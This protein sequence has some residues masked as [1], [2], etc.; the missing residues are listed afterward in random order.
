MVESDGRERRSIRRASPATRSSVGRPANAAE[1]RRCVREEVSAGT[2]R[3]SNDCSHGGAGLEERISLLEDKLFMLNAASWRE[4]W[5]DAKARDCDGIWQTV[6]RIETRVEEQL[7]CL[8]TQ[9]DDLNAGVLDSQRTVRGLVRDLQRSLARQEEFDRT[10]AEVWACLDEQGQQLSEA[11]RLMSEVDSGPEQ[12]ERLQAMPPMP[13]KS[14]VVVPKLPLSQALLSFNQDL[15]PAAAAPIAPARPA[16]ALKAEAAAPAHAGPMGACPAAVA[17]AHGGFEAAPRSSPVPPPP[18]M[19]PPGPAA[20]PSP[21]LSLHAFPE[22]R[23]DSVPHNRFFAQA[24]SS[25]RSVSPYLRSRITPGGT[26]PHVPPSPVSQPQLARSQSPM[27]RRRS[28]TP[29]PVH[30]LQRSPTDQPRRTAVMIRSASP[31]RCKAELSPQRRTS[32]SH[33]TRRLD[34]ESAGR[35][36]AAEKD[37]RCGGDRAG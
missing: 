8:R 15:A 5:A 2:V 3:S 21:S 10:L 29:V 35:S 36:G 7:R 20:P 26:T 16:S 13:P 12:E 6:Q 33:R 34:V 17:P 25:A 9:F 27:L 1:S 31:P 18:A 11:R 37:L 28:F 19:P 4:S 14:P 24:A 30:T 32:S 23:R 22:Q